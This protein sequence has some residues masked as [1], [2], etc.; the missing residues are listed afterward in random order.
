MKII[1]FGENDF[2]V[3]S[4]DESIFELKIHCSKD[5]LRLFDNRELHAITQRIFDE[6]K[7]RLPLS[8]TKMLGKT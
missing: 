4:G 5:D 1:Q 3:E 8:E 2:V 6:Y 7:K